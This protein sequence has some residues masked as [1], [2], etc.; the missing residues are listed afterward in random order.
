ML[1]IVSNTTPIISLLKIGRFLILRN[2]YQEIYV[3]M[4]VYKELEKG[5]GKEY[6]KDLIY[7][8]FIVR[9]KREWDLA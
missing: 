9:I 4:E 5:K 2:L 6:Y 7:Q 8:T 1:K 3:P